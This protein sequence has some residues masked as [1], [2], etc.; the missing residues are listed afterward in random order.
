[1]TT[2]KS[3]TNQFRIRWVF[4]CCFMIGLIAVYQSHLGATAHKTAVVITSLDYPP[5]EWQSFTSQTPTTLT[6]LAPTFASPQ[7]T[8]SYIIRL[9][10]AQTITQSFH[11]TDT[12]PTSLSYIPNSATGGLGY[13]IKNHQLTWSGFIPPGVLGY[14][15]TAVTD[16]TYINLGDQGFPDLCAQFIN[17]DEGHM[18]FDLKTVGHSFTFFGKTWYQL[19]VSANG[20]ILGP[21]ATF[22]DACLACPQPLPNQAAPHQLIAGLWNDMDN[23]VSG[24]WHAGIITGV[25]T[26]PNDTVFYA[27]WHDMGHFIDPTLTTRSAVI[28]VL[29]SQSEPAGTIYVIIEHISD[30]EQLIENGYAIGLENRTGTQGTLYAFAPCTSQPCVILPP[31]G[32]LPPDK[33]VLRFEPAPISPLVFSFAARVNAPMGS[34]ITN[35]AVATT[36]AIPPSFL[37]SQITSTIQSTSLIPIL[38]R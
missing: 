2:I 14:K 4:V 8:I 11:L 3:L 15:V 1:M 35:T 38:K 31:V 9:E 37:I 5:S 34:V 32:I 13:D 30:R 23:R 33:T 20:L 29:D 10:H 24:Q 22:N 18:L 25:L 19:T 7:Q 16:T 26:N 6:K 21:E 12:L 27:N 28:L 17:C 36:N